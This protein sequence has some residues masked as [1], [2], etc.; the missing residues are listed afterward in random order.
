[1]CRTE[2]FPES[3]NAHIEKL[4]SELEPSYVLQQPVQTHNI[5]KNLAIFLKVSIH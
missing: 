2:R 3:F 1:M 4:V 5:N